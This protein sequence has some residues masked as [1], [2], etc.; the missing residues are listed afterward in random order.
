MAANNPPTSLRK[1]TQQEIANL[2]NLAI[3][4]QLA[5]L[6][7]AGFPRITPIWFL[8]EEGTFYMSSGQEK[9][10]VH[11]LARN[12]RAGLSIGVEEGQTAGGS[13][14]YRQIVVRG[15]AQVQPDADERWA[16]KLILKYISGQ[17]GTLRAQ[18]SAGK[19]LA[20]IMLRPERF[21]T[22]GY[23]PAQ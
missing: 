22:T 13:R 21:L 1:L 5:T 8:W 18:Q 20:V 7:A 14:P 19:P 17:A 10:H 12:P 15:Y 3:P 6:D 2:L 11:D 9:R 23:F 16:H 4:A